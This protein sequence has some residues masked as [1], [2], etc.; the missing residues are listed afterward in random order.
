M[1]SSGGSRS[2]SQ[3][4]WTS[5]GAQ[6]SRPASAAA[7][8]PD[9][10]TLYQ[11]LNVPF[12]AT[13]ADITRAYRESMRRVHPDRVPENRRAAAEN[14][15]KDLN[16]AYA[17]LSDPDK[18]RAY[19]QTIRQ[20]EM[21]DQIMRRYVPGFGGAGAGGV[22]PFAQGLRRD[23]TD[24]ERRDHRRSERSAF[25]TILSAFL[26]VTLGVIGLLILFSLAAWAVTRIF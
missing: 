1:A 6:R 12:T 4:P 19:D 18:R 17:I 15:A 22:D 24:S 25:I 5:Q 16:A 23:I 7:R 9:A 26:V 14:L 13:K 21:Q 20:Q 11:L 10:D 2:Q 3:G 8:E